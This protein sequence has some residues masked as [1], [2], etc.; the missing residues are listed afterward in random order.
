M[1]AGPAARLACDYFFF[2]APERLAAL[3]EIPTRM[4]FCC[5][6]AAVRP[7]CR[8]TALVAV[9][10]FASCLKVRN[11]V[12]PQEAPSFEGRFAIVDLH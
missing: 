1:R 5:T 11:S 12:A 7:S 9:P 6:A 2:R 10:A 8:A 3:N 4:A